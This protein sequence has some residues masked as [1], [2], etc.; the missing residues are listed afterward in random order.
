[1][2]TC[3]L[4]G[5][6]VLLA[7]LSASGS[8]YFPLATGNQ[9]VYRITG[10]SPSAMVVEVLSSRVEGDNTYFLV[11]GFLAEDVWLRAD[12]EG[13]VFRFA[14]AEPAETQL[15][16]FGLA[17]GEEYRTSIH[18][19]NPSARIDSKAAHY[20]GPIGGHDNTTHPP[21]T[22]PPPKHPVFRHTRCLRA[23]HGPHTA[24]S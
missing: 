24:S 2:R 16:A 7:C 14:P 9:W 23:V 15:Y 5:L 1:M 19:C 11:H 13:N 8:D 20:E 22:Q 12:G 17:E 6:L 10:G 3:L 4:I 21:F 18:G